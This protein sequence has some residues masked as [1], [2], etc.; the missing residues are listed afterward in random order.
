MTENDYSHRILNLH[1]VWQ[2]EHFALFHAHPSF[3]VLLLIEDVSFLV[4]SWRQMG[5]AVL[6]LENN[7]LV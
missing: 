1:H 2:T 3:V 5:F 4:H 6:G 7:G